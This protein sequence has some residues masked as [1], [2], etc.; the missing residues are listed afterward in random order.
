MNYSVL[1]KSL[2]AVCVTLGVSSCEKSTVYLPEDCSGAGSF[3]YASGKY[4]QQGRPFSIGY[5]CNLSEYAE[6]ITVEWKLDETGDFTV[7]TLENN[8]STVESL[9][10]TAGEQNVVVRTSYRY[11]DQRKSLLDTLSLSVVPPVLDGFFFFDSKE[12]ILQ[13]HPDAVVQ[14]F[15][16]LAIINVS[17]S[18]NETDTYILTNNSMSSASSKETLKDLTDPYQYM[19]G[20]IDNNNPDYQSVPKFSVLP[21][22]VSGIPDED[23]DDIVSLGDKMDEGNTLTQ[24]EIDRVN[25]YYAK[26]WLSISLDEIF[27]YGA[28][29]YKVNSIL[30][31]WEGEDVL[32]VLYSL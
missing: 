9:W 10:E 29:L 16:N 18:E 25:D 11:G 4:A 12:I 30:T 17:V 15:D 13:S 5:Q 8:V 14:D 19:Y 27:D 22:Y 21:T 20:L 7:E 6:D 28:L 24:D 31:K 26:G 2:L 3:G 23:M 32:D 1:W